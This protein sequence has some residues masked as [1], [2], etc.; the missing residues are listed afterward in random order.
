[1]C[2]VFTC[3]CTRPLFSPPPSLSTCSFWGLVYIS[4][5]YFVSNK[6]SEMYKVY[7]L[8]I[9]FG[10]YIILSP[11]WKGIDAERFL[12][13]FPFLQRRKSGFS[14]KKK[15]KCI[16]I[17]VPLLFIPRGALLIEMMNLDVWL[18]MMYS[19]IYVVGS[20]KEWPIFGN[21]II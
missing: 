10:F 5:F 4:R 14:K 20:Q 17:L 11:K 19:S 9:L 7:C 8:H 12:F 18:C 15:F 2:R 6:S 21:V 16:Q 3:W 1:M 13:V